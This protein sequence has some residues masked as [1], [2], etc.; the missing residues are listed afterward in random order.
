MLGTLLC[1]LGLHR[2]VTTRDKPKA[3]HGG[4]SPFSVIH[5][6][7]YRPHCKFEFS[8]RINFSS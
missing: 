8:K 6:A 7:C 4:H 1:W 2:V 3:G 5:G